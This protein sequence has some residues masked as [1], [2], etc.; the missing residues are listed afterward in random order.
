MF[1]NSQRETIRQLKTLIELSTI[2]NSTRDPHEVRKRAI[3][4]VTQIIDCETGSLLLLD[5]EKEELYFEVALGKKG[6]RIKE[7]RL[8][9]GEGIAGWVAKTRQP[10]VVH[11]ASKDPRHFSEAD[12]R[13]HFITRNIIAVPVM[14]KGKLI[15]V[16]EA[17]NKNGGS[18]F[19]KQ[20]LEILE[21]LSN[22][23][24]IAIDN[25]R[26]YEA[27][28]ETFLES[29]EANKMLGLTFQSK[30]MLE[31]AYERFKKVP[32][33]DD[34]MEVHYNLAFDCERKKLFDLALKNYLIVAER[35]PKY[36][37]VMERINL[38]QEGLKTKRMNKEVLGSLP[39]M[40][41]Q[42]EVSMGRIGDY[43]IL[44]QLGRGSIGPVFLGRDIRINRIVAI[45]V[46]NYPEGIVE[47]TKNM[48]R[49]IFWKQVEEMGR[50]IHPN[51]VTIYD[52]GE[53]YDI[54]Y[55]AMEFLDGNP[56]TYW[57][58]PDSL[59][60]IDEVVNIAMGICE[61]LSH[62]H[63]MVILHLNLKPS[64]VIILKDRRVK[65]TDFG[66]SRILSMVKKA[67]NKGGG[68]SG[69]EFYESP[70]KIKGKPEDARSDI[71]SLGVILYELLTGRK[72]FQG[73]N[74]EEIREEILFN[75]PIAPHIIR[76][77]VP[78]FVSRIVEKAIMRNI[79]K[80]FQT[81]S[82]MYNYL[83][84]FSSNMGSRGNDYNS[85]PSI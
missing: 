18:P 20:D 64:N 49:E 7:M 27:I 40:E 50:L 13:S 26:L 9:V 44:K 66:V 42:T 10:I 22:H 23:V 54:P 1:S 45:K 60:E 33:D 85:L 62:A 53:E 5:E 48:L 59:L 63:K 74:V 29:A 73:K 41:G 82:E 81:V 76:P 8:K 25:A 84:R 80:R 47:E 15:G 55:L 32:M 4:A 14:A 52:T 30:G 65:V 11:D 70:E 58:R 75:V 34:M 72:P 68:L 28:K 37:D 3:E 43:E 46:F 35:N 83:N 69:T 51:I 12:S 38:L 16:L 21:M 56:L 78:E 36:R 19:Y 71:F 17:I 6:E 2:L 79:E 57:C 31:L 39:F 24:G 67:F 61:A 77:S